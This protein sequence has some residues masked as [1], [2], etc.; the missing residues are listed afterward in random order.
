M[1]PSLALPRSRKEANRGGKLVPLLGPPFPC[2]QPFGDGGRAG[3]G[4]QIPF[5]ARNRGDCPVVG[6][7]P[8]AGRSATGERY[9]PLPGPPPFAKRGKQGRE[10]G[11]TP[12]PSLPLSPAL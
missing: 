5:I 9:G 12:R 4:G 11:P 7:S 2:R 3:D 6:I 10:T 8:V 1:A